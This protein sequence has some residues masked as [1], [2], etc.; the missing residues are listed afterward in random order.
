MIKISEE[1]PDRSVCVLGL[2]YVGL[3][4]ATVLAGAG[5][6]V[7]GVEVRED[8]VDQ[9]RRG[10]PH[11][12]EPGL[13]ER[14]RKLVRRGQLRIDTAIPADCPAT[15]F[16]ITVGTPLLGPGRIRL[17]MIERVSQ[18]IAAHLKPGDMVIARS[19]VR[20]GTTRKVVMPILDGAGVPYHMAFCPE[21]T[22]EG[23]ALTELR[24][25]PQIVGANEPAARLRASRFFNVITPTVVQVPS[26]EVAE[27]VKLI[28]NTYR[29]V[30]F[31]FA[32]EVARMCDAAGLSAVEVI[33]AGK[34]SY[35]RTN[36]PLPGPVGGP[37]LEKD[38]HIL[39]ESLRAFGFEPEMVGI[40][41][42]MN[43]TQPAD[44]VDRL[45]ALAD[46]LPGWPARP[47]IALMGLAFKGR[48]VTDDLRGTMAK[49]MVEA[50]RRAF[51][52]A[53]LR[54]FDAVVAPEAISATFG[55]APMPSM[56]AAMEGANLVLIANNHPCFQGMILEDLAETL[57]RPAVVYDFWNHFA[58]R[59]LDLPEGV[60]YVALGD[61]GLPV[62]VPEL[63]L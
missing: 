34:L 11:F 49:P 37:C 52:N 14:L 30:T 61:G 38:P 32:N 6:Q 39:T 63:A 29:D 47:V 2:G 33:N 9:L 17:D 8:V 16:I 23:Q 45:R 46:T 28:D 41:R 27:M 3:T 7:Q 21:R 31:A 12:F 10:E 42:A 60:R 50:L 13:S 58:A 40:A 55:I 18:D 59:D 20:L 1:F 53:T 51:P 56:E 62:T 25:L 43:E 22:V 24:W 19:T 15:V 48:P 26:I 36:L 35:P 44:V 54:G 5:F 57:A 4:L